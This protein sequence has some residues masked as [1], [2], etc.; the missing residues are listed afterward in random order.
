MPL[1]GQTDFRNFHL[2]YDYIMRLPAMDIK[3]ESLSYSISVVIIK[4]LT[5]SA[6]TPQN[7][8]THSNNS[9]AANDKLFERV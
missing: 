3:N 4:H 1:R 9:L 6:P 7:V 2:L 5:L 8:Q